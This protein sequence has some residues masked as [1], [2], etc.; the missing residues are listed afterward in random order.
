MFLCQDDIIRGVIIPRCYY[1]EVL[2]LRGVITPRQS[3]ISGCNLSFMYGLVV[4]VKSLRYKYP[5]YV[6]FE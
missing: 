5:R 4:S 6:R 2:S 3:F 1:S